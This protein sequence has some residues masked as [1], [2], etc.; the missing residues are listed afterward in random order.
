MQSEAGPKGIV[1]SDSVARAIAFTRLL[2]KMRGQLPLRP[3]TSQRL[4]APG[5]VYYFL[6]E[7][8]EKT[9]IPNTAL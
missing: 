6:L 1:R 4:Q 2:V 9:M 5:R 7:L 3:I 8:S